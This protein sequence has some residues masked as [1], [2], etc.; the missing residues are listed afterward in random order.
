MLHIILFLWCTSALSAEWHGTLTSA[1]RS[2]R[3]TLDTSISLLKRVENEK[4]IT[5]TDSIPVSK[6]DTTKIKKA[7]KKHLTHLQQMAKFRTNKK[8]YSP[9]EGELEGAWGED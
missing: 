1:T 6:K 5:A 9:P 2:D 4:A 3:A 7:N 8:N